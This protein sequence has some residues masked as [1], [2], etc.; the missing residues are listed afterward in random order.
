MLMY[1]RGQT[2]HQIRGWPRA[3]NLCIGLN[4]QGQT[5]FVQPKGL[6]LDQN[7]RPAMMDYFTMLT[8]HAERAPVKGM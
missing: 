2:P 6:R 3:T 1:P 5:L 8:V 4:Y 7:C